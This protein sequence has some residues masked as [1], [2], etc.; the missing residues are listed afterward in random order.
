MS[1]DEDDEDDDLGLLLLELEEDDEDS[2]PVGTIS[3]F[4]PAPLLEIRSMTLAILFLG[5]E[6]DE[7]DV[8][9]PL[10]KS[11]SRFFAE[12]RFEYCMDA[13]YLMLEKV[14]RYLERIDDHRR[15]Q[16]SIFR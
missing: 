14:T 6:L 7:D 12:E 8:L 2:F 10:F 16:G 5:D 11:S 1:Q 3:M 15:F 13:Y 4:P 9:P